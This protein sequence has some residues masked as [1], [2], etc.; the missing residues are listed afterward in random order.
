M[1]PVEDH[2]VCCCGFS[3]KTIV[4]DVV[5]IYPPVTGQRPTQSAERSAHCFIAKS[6]LCQRILHL[7]KNSTNSNIPLDFVEFSSTE[8]A[9]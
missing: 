6:N 3:V 8:F 5:H 1:F 9:A 7:L 2:L 4:F